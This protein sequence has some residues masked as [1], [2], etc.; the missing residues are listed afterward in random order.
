MRW[1]S[2]GMKVLVGKDADIKEG[3]LKG[4]VADGR[5]YVVGRY[6]GRLFAMDGKCSHAGFDLI[7]GTIRDGAVICPAHGAAFDISDG[8]KVAHAGARDLRVYIVSLE[9]EDVHVEI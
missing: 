5:K 1:D 2:T 9:G 4:F 6:D 8:R 3:R 7:Y